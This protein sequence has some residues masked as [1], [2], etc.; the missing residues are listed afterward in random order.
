LSASLGLTAG[1]LVVSR[2]H[3]HR[4][5]EHV[6]QI[7]RDSGHKGTYGIG[8][9]LDSLVPVLTVNLKK[10]SGDAKTKFYTL[11]LSPKNPDVLKNISALRKAIVN[12]STKVVEE[13]GQK[14]FILRHDYKESTPSLK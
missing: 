3:V 14:P 4:K 5:S 9:G 13:H 11:N 8:F 1:H 10:A 2:F 7:Y 6:F 12:S